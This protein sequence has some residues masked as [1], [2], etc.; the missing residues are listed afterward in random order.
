MLHADLTTGYYIKKSLI[1][2]YIGNIIGALLVALPAVYF[3][4]GDWKAGGLVDAEEART[5]KSSHTS[6]Q[7][8]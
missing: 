7:F 3:Y 1:A 6:L 2:A 4:L 5:E 8:E